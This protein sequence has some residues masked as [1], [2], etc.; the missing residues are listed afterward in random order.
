MKTRICQQT[1]CTAITAMGTPFCSATRLK[2]WERK[3]LGFGFGEVQINFAL[4]PRNPK[5][6]ELATGQL[7]HFHKQDG[8]ED[9]CR[10]Q[11]FQTSLVNSNGKGT[12]W[13]DNNCLYSIE[14]YCIIYLYL[15]MYG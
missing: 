10:E 3:S 9:F 2:N 7:D 11:N 5:M 14:L 6:I 1:F 13:Q 15:C 12:N 4:L 8:G